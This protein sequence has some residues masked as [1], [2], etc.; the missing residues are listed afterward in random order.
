VRGGVVTGEDRDEARR[1]AVA[2]REVAHLLGERG[3]PGARER[4]AVE[5]RGRQ[6]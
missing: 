2:F 3:A 6:S 4:D 5:N 1:L